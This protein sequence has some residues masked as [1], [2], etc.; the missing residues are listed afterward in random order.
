MFQTTIGSSFEE[1]QAWLERNEL[2]AIPTETVYGLAANAFSVEAILK[3]FHTKSRPTFNPLIVHAYDLN[4]ASPLVAAWHPKLLE[5]Y[6]A[7]AP[8]PI[9]FLVS[10]TDL[11]H[12]LITAGQERVAMRFP[13]HPLTQQLLKNLSFPLVAPSANPFGYVSPTTAHHVYE[14]LNSKIPYILDGGNCRLGIESTIVG[15]ENQNDLVI[16]RLG[17]IPLENIENIAGKVQHIYRSSSKPAAPGMLMKHYAPNKPLYLVQNLSVAVKKLLEKQEAFGIISFGKP[18]Q[19]V[20]YQ[21]DLSPSKNL[22]EAAANFFKVLR[23]I[24]TWDVPYVIIEPFPDRLLGKALN[25]K[26]QRA[27]APFPYPL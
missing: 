26:L 4:Q 23:T 7:F 19:E 15:I 11:V 20:A 13:A 5:L 17:S 2:V 18:F 6:H 12:D 3:V 25:D 8:G 14:Q 9:T 27:T 21:S 22:E 1:A 10:K 16:Y 24:E